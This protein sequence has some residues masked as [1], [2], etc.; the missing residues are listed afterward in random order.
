MSRII[1]LITAIGAALLVV[2]AAWGQTQP[3]ARDVG[4]N[5]LYGLGEYSPEARAE[6]L[7]SEGL[8][9]LYG[10][11]E[12]ATTTPEARAEKLRGEGLNKLYGLGEWATTTPA[13]IEVR[14]RGMSVGRENPTISMLDT[15]EQAFGAKLN[16]QLSTGTS[17][18]AFQ[19]AVAANERSKPVIVVDDRFRIDPTS[20]PVSTSGSG[21]EIQWPQVGVGFGVGIT[22]VFGLLLALRATRQRQLAH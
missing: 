15:R 4:M 8:N 21:D 22:L 6:K 19:R 11:G 7:R 14:E 1:T 20:Q 13:S 3:D 5:K 12:W 9:K 16:A 2:P 10:L 17:P 18:D